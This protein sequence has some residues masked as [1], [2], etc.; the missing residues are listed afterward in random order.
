MVAVLL[1]TSLG[2]GVGELISSSKSSA[3]E[4]LSKWYI[5]Y[6]NTGGNVQSSATMSDGESIDIIIDT[7]EFALNTT[8]LG[9]DRICN[10]SR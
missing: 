6:E 8:L 10:G 7:S 4:G 2:G 3:P 5:T 1:I 9:I